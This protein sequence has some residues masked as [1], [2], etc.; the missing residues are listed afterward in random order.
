MRFDDGVD[1]D[2][3][4]GKFRQKDVTDSKLHLPSTSLAVQSVATNDNNNR[5][6]C[7]KF[8]FNSTHQ[9]FQNAKYPESFDAGCL[10]LSC[11]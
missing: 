9:Q 3:Q 11:G 7:V 1:Y 5:N 8:N 6:I 10:E 4:S 2:C